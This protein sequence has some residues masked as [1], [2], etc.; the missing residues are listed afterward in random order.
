MR[1]N[2]NLI[3]FVASVFGFV[4]TIRAQSSYDF[5]TVLHMGLNHSHQMKVSEADSIIRALEVKKAKLN[6]TPEVSVTGQ[7]MLLNQPDIRLMGQPSS[8][9]AP[10]NASLVMG[11]V[12]LPIFTGFQLKNNLAIS[13]EMQLAEA[14]NRVADS[15]TVTM[16]VIEAYLSLYKAQQ[17][18]ELVEEN[19]KVAEKR[20]SDFEKLVANDIITEN[21]LLK[22]KIQLSRLRSSQLEISAQ[23][24]LAAYQLSLLTGI[25]ENISIEVNSSIFSQVPAIITQEEFDA[26]LL[27]RNDYKAMEHQVKASE[28]IVKMQQANYYPHVSLSGMY[29]SAYVPNTLTINNMINAGVTL[30][31]DL[32]ALYKNGTSVQV[33]KNELM[34]INAQLEQLSD[35][36]KLETR[37]SF[38][39]YQTAVSQEELH[40]EIVAQSEEN[41]RE[42]SKKFENQLVTPT[43]ILEAETQKLQAQIDLKIAEAAKFQAYC[44][45]LKNSGNLNQ[46][47]MI[48]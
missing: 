30:K 11:S 7:T 44:N 22:A 9:A 2:N 15:T 37:K 17:A 39:D 35:R 41:Y 24:E 4:L 10:K 48:K 40:Q 16:Q 31:Y 36:I 47:N 34:R 32:S 46:L 20:I 21:D 14:E 8:M 38:L 29:V 19:V 27:N 13:K 33:K 45:Y 42:I 12:G 1:I 5:Q 25:P 3:L 23:N 18:K 26:I 28:Y 6:Y 43:D